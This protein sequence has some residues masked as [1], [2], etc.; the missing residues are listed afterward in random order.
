[1]LKEQAAAASIG[2]YYRFRSPANSSAMGFW[3]V[4][5]SGT[6]VS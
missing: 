3:E 2:F 6:S 1:L 5:T 4:P